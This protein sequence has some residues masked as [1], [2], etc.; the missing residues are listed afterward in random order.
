[1]LGFLAKGRKQHWSDFV[2][3]LACRL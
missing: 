2:V 1:L 3:I